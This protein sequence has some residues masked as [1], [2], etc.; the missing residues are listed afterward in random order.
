MEK[1]NIS[2][3]LPKNFKCTNIQMFLQPNESMG[4]LSLFGSMKWIVYGNII[5][6][7]DYLPYEGTLY[8]NLDC[9]G[10]IRQWYLVS[11]DGDILLSN[12]NTIKEPYLIIDAPLYLKTSKKPVISLDQQLDYG[13]L[14][15]N[16]GISKYDIP[17][18]LKK[19]ELLTNRYM[20]AINRE[21]PDR[22]EKINRFNDLII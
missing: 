2:L 5:M 12:Y 9:L 10:F 21:L 19:Y 6:L 4:Y 16:H 13:V 3:K 1:W 14:V 22:K 18:K 8:A 17:E 15:E 7:N 20:K 11:M